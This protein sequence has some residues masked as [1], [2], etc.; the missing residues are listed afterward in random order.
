VPPGESSLRLA[1]FPVPGDDPP[2]YIEL[3]HAAV[4]ERGI[5]HVRAAR[6]GP[7]L[8]RESRDRPDVV[9]LHWI[10]YLVRGP[11]SGP[12]ALA[13][14]GARTARLAAGLRLLRRHGVGIVWTVHNLQPHESSY[15]RLE[16]AAV[17]ATAQSAHRLIVHSNHARKR[18]AE[19]YGQD[20][21]LT[22]IPHG[23]FIGS[24]PPPRHSREEV[25]AMLGLSRDA[26][27]FLIFGQVRRY[28]RIPEAIAAFRALPSN[29]VALVVAGSAWDTGEREAVQHAAAGDPRIRLRLGFVPNEDIR[30]LHLAVDAAVLAYHELFSSGAL[31]LALSLGVPAVVPVVGSALEV[32]TPPAVEPFEDGGFMQALETMTT[33]DHSARRAAAQAAAEGAGWQGIG[34]RTALVYREA[35]QE[36]AR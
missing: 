25:R 11:G 33:G 35:S 32:A 27:A 10:E 24:Y 12:R 14:S 3:L 6:L 5:R 36:A 19:A 23:N 26:F 15:P 30:E 20:A 31:L 17:R 2:A 9:H 7:R 28:K 13:R 22:V 34:E 29:D 1:S 8:A 21:K 4:A 16:A 18:V